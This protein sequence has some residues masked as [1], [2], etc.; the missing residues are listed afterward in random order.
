MSAA[1]KSRNILRGI[2]SRLKKRRT[3]KDIGFWRNNASPNPSLEEIRAHLLLVQ[4]IEYVDLAQTCVLSFLYHHPK[5]TFTFHCDEKTIE[6][7]KSKFYKEIYE[8]IVQLRLLP[9]GAEFLWQEIKL[10]TILS[11]SGTSDLML[12]ADL[13]WNSHLPPIDAPLFFVKEFDFRDKSP[14]REITME[15]K[16]QVLDASMKNVSVFSFG[17]YR[18]TD[19]EIQAIRDSMA[20]YVRIVNSETV[21][22]LDKGSIERVIE[23]FVLSLCCETWKSEIHFVKETDKPLDGGIVESCYFGATGGTF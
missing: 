1:V 8:G 12:D 22:S 10:E 11:M 6:V 7:V 4:K 2:E 3:S 9:A 19:S 17:N 13:R 21:G 16:I 15:T 14:F 5:A 20:E 23:Q 18:L